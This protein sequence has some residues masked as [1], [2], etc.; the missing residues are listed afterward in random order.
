[1][2]TSD[3]PD[4]SQPRRR[5][6]IQQPLRTEA[7]VALIASEGA[8]TDELEARLKRDHPLITFPS[9]SHFLAEP[10]RGKGYAAVVVA[11]PTAWDPNLD[12]YVR[13]RR[14]IALFALPEEGY[15]WPDAV[16]R[17]RDL[18][19]MDSWL[20][21][22]NAPEQPVLKKLAK[23]PPATPKAAAAPAPA[24][25]LNEDAR[26][27]E[28][29]TPSAAK[30]GAASSSEPVETKTP[31]PAAARKTLP[32]TKAASQRPARTPQQLSL[33][34]LTESNSAKS[35]PRAGRR[36]TAARAE[37][38]PA[39]KPRKAR[40]A[41]E[42]PTPLQGIPA[43]DATRAVR[44]VLAATSKETSRD[45]AAALAFTR[46]AAE[47]GLVRADE[48]LSTLRGRATQLALNLSR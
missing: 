5:R 24:A 13:R 48:L 47:V 7:P 25:W 14:S 46:A 27:W 6:I 18:G 39:A 34:E 17:L 15:G 33:A 23:R 8:A 42:R 44:D 16:A 35:S 29:L 45:L 20:A 26:V 9:L 36:T 21:G 1:M 43:I 3:T 41:L 19:E 22:L 40:G 38:K 11:R 28:L 2:Y 31:E 12:H 37:P 4:S 10:L 32:P 30:P